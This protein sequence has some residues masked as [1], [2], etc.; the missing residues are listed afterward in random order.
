VDALVHTGLVA[1]RSEARRAV[2]DGGAYVNNVRVSDAD[3][4]LS[5]DALLHGEWLVLRRGKRH[6][7]GLQLLR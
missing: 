7:A 1:S 4:A 3:A 2:Q 5:Q 6:V